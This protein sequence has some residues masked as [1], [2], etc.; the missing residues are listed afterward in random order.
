MTVK[1]GPAVTR[2]SVRVAAVPA[3]QEVCVTRCARADSSVLTVLT[4][5][6][7]GTEGSVTG[8]TG[9]VIVSLAGWVRT[10]KWVSALNKIRS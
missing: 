7:A 3:G 4:S 9:A 1:T 5:A 8:S 2:N 6:C 10:V